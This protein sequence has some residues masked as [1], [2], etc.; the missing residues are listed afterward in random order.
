MENL[1][2]LPSLPLA[3][4]LAGLRL[5]PRIAHK[6]LT[7]WPLLPRSPHARGRTYTTLG[8]GLDD[9]FA[10]VAEAEPGESLA[11]VRVENRGALPLL[12]AAGE[13]IAC[14][15]SDAVARASVLVPARGGALVELGRADERRGRMSRELVAWLREV[16]PL[17]GQIGLVAALGD[18]VLGL[19]LA[20]CP[21]AFADLLASVLARFWMQA[22]EI[23]FRSGPAQPPRFDA[24]ESLLDALA[25]AGLRS[26]ASAGPGREVLL[27]GP[28]VSGRALVVEEEVVHWVT[29]AR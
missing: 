9:G 26:R 28:G 25:R 22:V 6:A 20:A 11:R 18:R 8:R 13:E 7:A 17:P 19:E 21:F 16:R 5:A 23:A 2:V 27:E 29:L 24:P 4:T 15:Q 1:A 3:R 14:T 10:G 12:V